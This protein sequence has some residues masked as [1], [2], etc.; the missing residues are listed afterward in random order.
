M[1]Y[2][3]ELEEILA[4][5]RVKNTNQEKL[6]R[7]K[8]AEDLINQ[9]R[10]NKDLI[11]EEKQEKIINYIE[12]LIYSPLI[13]LE[14]G[15]KSKYLNKILNTI[16]FE[17]MDEFYGFLDAL[18]IMKVYA[19]TNSW[20]EVKN[21]LKRQEHTRYSM[22]SVLEILLEYSNIGV[23]FTNIFANNIVKEN[24]E[25]NR[26]YQERIQ[27]EMKSTNSRKR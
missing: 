25:L 16:D 17:I 12:S 6:I 18:E 8:R 9:F 14:K 4:E 11:I 26:L 27:N 22:E 24:M 20:E 1:K 10:N 15:K 21:T 23:D 5:I 2:Q 3:I 13:V 19:K 7:V